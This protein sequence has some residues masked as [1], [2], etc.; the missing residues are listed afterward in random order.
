MG[1]SV[2][3][4]NYI[5]NTKVQGGIIPKPKLI[6][7]YRTYGKK[8]S[9]SDRNILKDLSGK[10]HDIGLYNFSYAYGNGYGEHCTQFNKYK[11]QTDRD[12]SIISVDETRVTFQMKADM[13]GKCNFDFNV[14]DNTV[15]P[16]IDNYENTVFYIKTHSNTL[17]SENCTIDSS[18]PKDTI[19]WYNYWPSSIQKPFK[20]NGITAITPLT[21]E[22]FVNTSSISIQVDLNNLEE[23]KTYD[24]TFELIPQ[25]TGGLIFNGIDSYGYCNNFPILKKETGYTVIALRKWL[26]LKDDIN[27]KR[28]LTNYTDSKN[29]AF[30]M[31]SASLIRANQTSSWGPTMGINVIPNVLESNLVVYQTSYDYN[32]IRKIQISTEGSDIGSN[33][34][35]LGN[36]KGNTGAGFANM[37]FYAAEIYD[38]DLTPEE[39]EPIKQRML[40]EWYEKAF[41]PSLVGYQALWTCNGK[42]NNDVDKNIPN[43]ADSTNPLVPRNFAW[44]SESG[45]TEN[46]LLFD[47]IDNSVRTASM[48]KDIGLEYTVIGDFDSTTRDGFAKQD[49]NWYWYQNTGVSPVYSI[50][51][52]NLDSSLINTSNAVAI[53]FNSEGLI[54]HKNAGSIKGLSG[55]IHKE[56]YFASIRSDAGNKT[57]R[58]FAIIP[59]VLTE[60]QIRKVYEYL[61]TIKANN[62]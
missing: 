59:R 24:L 37:V 55:N 61:K 47:G 21:L 13:M 43:L 16:N 31:E 32:G 58:F 45:Y 62:I 29:T 27:L 38:G 10:G 17:T 1:I 49:S 57:F 23:G 2:G 52:S 39:I 44:N 41:D 53:G 7:S 6:A 8:N 22:Q 51:I 4:G 48:L 30:L 33:Q 35:T 34:L 14:T 60:A 56:A 40:D 3:I 28:F 42:T 19:G 26:S 20:L 25:Y 50:Y 18:F 54:V 36:L 9:D 11:L 46:G 5:G 12:V 15:I